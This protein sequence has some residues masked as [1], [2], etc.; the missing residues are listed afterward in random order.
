MVS[1]TDLALARSAGAP[2][3]RGARL[4]AQSPWKTTVE[5]RVEQRKQPPGWAGGLTEHLNVPFGDGIEAAAGQ[6]DNVGLCGLGHDGSRSL[7][8]VQGLPLFVSRYVCRRRKEGEAPAVDA[9]DSK[10]PL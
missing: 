1:G 10:E 2:L 6:Q 5:A 7:A 3:Q 9:V 4:S 8:L